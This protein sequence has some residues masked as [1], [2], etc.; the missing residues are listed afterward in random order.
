MNRL[1][2]FLLILLI[3][4]VNCGTRS[5][6]IE[7]TTDVILFTRFSIRSHALDFDIWGYNLRTDK[8]YPLATDAQYWEESPQWID[9]SRF[10]Y[11]ASMPG[12]MMDY[13][14]KIVMYNLQTGKRR[15][16]YK[17]SATA[18][19]EITSFHSKKDHILVNE[20]WA[21]SEIDP[22]GKKN[23]IVSTLYLGV[24][25]ITH[26]RVSPD[27]K[28]LVFAG[29]DTLK[30]K[31]LPKYD[32]PISDS[33]N[34]IYLYNLETKEL[35]Q[36]TNTDACDRD[37][38]W[39]PTGDKIIFSSNRDGNFEL[40]TMDLNGK[41]LQRITYTPDIDETE[42]TIAPDGGRVAFTDMGEG[43][44]PYIWVMNIDGTARKRIVVNG[45][46]PAWCPKK[47]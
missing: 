16:I 3:L 2:L 23:E 37:P 21:F 17:T 44:L 46:A 25:H 8:E 33:L 10:I 38:E 14:G 34:D 18:F 30:S 6:V 27:G 45:F 26:P 13:G 42:P 31:R 20:D 1:V 11:F 41:N 15:I 36:L 9:G 12:R 35:R 47:E 40:Y 32:R 22:T 28:W 5:V 29:V 39:F 4:W 7:D 43:H 24:R 19:S